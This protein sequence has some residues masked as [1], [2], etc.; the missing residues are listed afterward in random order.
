M[1][2][3]QFPRVSRGDFVNSG[4]M[5]S[6]YAD[7]RNND[8]YLKQFNTP[9]KGEQAEMLLRLIEVQRW[10][11]PSEK[12]ILLTRF[13]WPT[14]GFGTPDNIIGYSMPKAPRDAYFSL[15]AAGRTQEKLLQLKFLMDSKY[16]SGK[17]IASAKPNVSEQDRL[18]IAIELVDAIQVVHHHGLVYGDVSSNN[19]C[20]RLGESPSVFLLDADSIVTPD[21][22]A[23]NPVRTPGWPVPDNLDPVEA[24]R[25][26]ISLF[27]WRFMLEDPN[28]LP[29]NSAIPRFHLSEA[30]QFV[31]TL[32]SCYESGREADFHELSHGLRLVRDDSRDS[33][34]ILR[35]ANSYFARNVIREAIEAKS[36]ADKNIVAKAQS[37]VV[38]ERLV[39][40]STGTRQRIL[41]SRSVHRAD[42]FKLDL[43]PTI[44]ASAPPSTETELREMILDARETEL[45]LHLANGDLKNLESDTWLPRA[46]EHAIIEAGFA[47]LSTRNSV[48]SSV[49][50]W[51][52]PAAPYVNYAELRIKLSSGK[53]LVEKI[54]RDPR[55]PDSERSLQLKGG[56]KL[57][58]D[59]VTGVKSPSQNIYLAADK[60]RQDVIVL[61]PPRPIAI[62]RNLVND[63]DG[64]AVIIDLEEQQRLKEL[65]IA[66]AR[67]LK[68]NKI[69][70]A[71]ASIVAI[72]SLALGYALFPKPT[73][74]KH[75]DQI[76]LSN[77]NDCSYAMTGEISRGDFYRI[78]KNGTFVIHNDVPEVPKEG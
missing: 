8:L 32:I 21:I 66:E 11:R 26:L 34:A 6:V 62:T 71:A 30:K 60:L 70:S 22:R 27:V 28:A 17:A 16:F 61:P 63:D 5:G 64:D 44:T 72:A 56:G 55:K 43:S 54:K 53:V 9:L 15:T 35:A 24:D 78:S 50:H 18:E 48:E 47:T 40:S 29:N 25:S 73:E 41:I 20:A 51:T 67:R 14:E 2:I 31:S 76:T 19:M 52:W 69:I 58:V 12:E 13:S 68:R 65:A 42:G 33:R 57:Q 49:I 77:L 59:L 46:I 1:L 37:Q 3:P 23:K 39:E 4:G 36:D 75:C 7:P 45:A 74:D 38:F 10:A